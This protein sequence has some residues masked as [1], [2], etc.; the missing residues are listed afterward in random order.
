MDL[1]LGFAWSNPQ[2]LEFLLSR[3]KFYHC[4]T[5]SL[6]FI[7]GGVLPQRPRHQPRPRGCALH[8]G[9]G[10]LDED[11]KVALLDAAQ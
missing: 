10:A 7:S 9:G 8:P 6:D 3:L 1:I 4:A 5:T 11:R 2:P